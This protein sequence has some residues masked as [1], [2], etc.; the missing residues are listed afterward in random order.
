MLKKTVFLSYEFGKGKYT[1]YPLKL[2]RF[3]EEKKLLEIAK[4]HFIFMN[5]V[6]R[7]S[8]VKRLKKQFFR[9]LP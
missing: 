2:S 1:F 4:F 8:D 5:Q 9:V 3:T 7:L 6:K